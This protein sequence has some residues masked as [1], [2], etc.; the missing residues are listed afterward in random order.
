MIITQSGSGSNTSDFAIRSQ[1]FSKDLND[2]TQEKSKSAEEV[3]KHIN[4]INFNK[5]SQNHLYQID[6]QN[7][8]TELFKNYS[9][10]NVTSDDEKQTSQNGVLL[11]LLINSTPIDDINWSCCYKFDT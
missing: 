9:Q 7:L 6:Y 1:L 8:K 4:E 10:T 2:K 5:K 3:A 11:I